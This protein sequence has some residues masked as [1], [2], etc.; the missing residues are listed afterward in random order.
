MA[1]LD[2]V[3]AIALD[4]PGGRAV[5]GHR[6]GA[7]WRTTGGPFVWERGPSG[8]DLEQLAA[9]GRE[10]PHGDVIG[11][12][13]RRAAGEGGPAGD[14]PRRVLHDPAL[15]RLPGRAR[16]P[17]RDRSEQLREVITDAWLL[18]V[19]KR[20]AANGSPRTRR[21]P[22]NVR[23]RRRRRRSRRRR[24][25][26]RRAPRAATA[27]PAVKGSM[28]RTTKSAAKPGAMRPRQSPSPTEAAASLVA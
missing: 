13:Y 25:S 28:S 3:R 5:D 22:D 14:L 24:W 23:A 15:R 9:L 20:V 12:P 16:A 17:R 2:D 21:Q 7:S 11:R 27:A 18:K 4:L 8:R 10:W 19:T 26:A 1:T 6:G